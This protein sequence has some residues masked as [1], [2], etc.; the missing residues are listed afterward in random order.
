MAPEVRLTTLDGE[1]ISTSALRGKVVLVNFWAT[2]C[3]DC[4]REMPK[5]VET[6]RKYAPHGYEMLAVAV[7]SDD[8]AQVA[9]FARQRA[10]PFR[11]GRDGTGAIARRF[12]EIRITPQS[13][14]IDR[15]GRI[16]QRYVGEPDWAELHARL[17]KLVGR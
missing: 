10:L 15:D 13:I 11:V 7:Q 9:A 1:T 16:V 17:D 14:L 6:Y 4:L 12:G 8:A 3:P 2:W 5:M